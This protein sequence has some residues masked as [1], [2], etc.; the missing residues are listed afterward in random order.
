LIYKDP[1]TGKDTDKL[2]AIFSSGN[3]AQFDT[4]TLEFQGANKYNQV[5]I[6]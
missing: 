3:V 4:N 1:S 5:A 6:D 2:I